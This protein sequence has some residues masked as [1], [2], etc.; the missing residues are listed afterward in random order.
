[1]TSQHPPIPTAARA[2]ARD[3]AARFITDQQ[4]A[5]RLNDAG[6]R[7]RDANQRLWSGLHPD[8]LARLYEQTARSGD[9][10]IQSEVAAVLLDE[11]RG[12]AEEAKARTAVLAM[13]QEIHWVVHR[14]FS[15]YQV[16]CE[17]RRQLA[18]EVGELGYQLVDALV[19][20]GWTEA[21]A[22]DTNVHHLAEKGG[23]EGGTPCH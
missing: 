7:L 14:A 3:L 8:G 22:R 18:A 9:Q 19:A 16:A 15:D 6:S 11:A 21:Q 20:A 12:G 17:E 2:L 23:D 10:P 4:I 1:M 5:C 13:V